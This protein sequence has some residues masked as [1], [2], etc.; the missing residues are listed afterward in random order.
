MKHPDRENTIR[1]LFCYPVSIRL[2]MGQMVHPRFPKAHPFTPLETPKVQT[3]SKSSGR[4]MGSDAVSPDA[5]FG[6]GLFILLFGRL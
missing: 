2:P 4:H 5:G 3:I 1:V 6:S